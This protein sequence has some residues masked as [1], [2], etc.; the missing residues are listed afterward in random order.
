MLWTP[1]GLS[2]ASLTQMLE[3]PHALRCVFACGWL[4]RVLRAQVVNQ[5]KHTQSTRT[6]KSKVTRAHK[7]KGLA[8]NHATTTVQ[9][10][11]WVC[12]WVCKLCRM[13]SSTWSSCVYTWTLG[14]SDLNILSAFPCVC[15]ARAGALDQPGGG[16]AARRQGRAYWSWALLPPVQQRALCTGGATWQ[17]LVI[18]WLSSFAGLVSVSRLGRVLGLWQGPWARAWFVSG[19]LGTRL[20]RGR[21][22]GHALGS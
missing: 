11:A 4:G 3:G 5:S 7:D 12:I 21:G 6:E 18:Q 16:G 17:Y 22:L 8:D 2:S 13:V 19:A 1:G 14:H 9:V 20:V 15:V 10:G